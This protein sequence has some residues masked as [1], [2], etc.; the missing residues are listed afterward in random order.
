VALVVDRDLDAGVSQS[1]LEDLRRHPVLQG[2]DREGVPLVVE[3]DPGA[4]ST[5][6]R[7]SEMSDQRES[8]IESTA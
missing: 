5:G 4:P 2:E 3:A 7:S 1:L 8:A 6:L